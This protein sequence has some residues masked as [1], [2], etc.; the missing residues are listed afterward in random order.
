MPRFRKFFPLVAFLLFGS[1]AVI[2][3]QNQNRYEKE[4][5]FRNTQTSSEQIRIRV[6]GLMNARMAS[7]ELLADRWVERTPPDFSRKR[8]LEFA[9]NFYT[10]YPGFTE[11]NWIDPGGDVR[12][13]FPRESN[14]GSTGNMV[15]EHLNS[16]VR[17]T[18]KKAG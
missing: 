18:F 4:L 10:H 5:V 1:G 3:W 12:W 8:F 9:E 14:E 16:R 2:L 7:L 13:V 17:D 15:Y 11:I 6:E